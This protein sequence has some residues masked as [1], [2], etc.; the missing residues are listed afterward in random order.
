MARVRQL[1]LLKASALIF[2]I[3]LMVTS[4]SAK[5]SDY[6]IDAWTSDSGLP[7]SSVTS[8]A[9]TQDGY[10]WVGTS[11]GLARFDGVRFETFD[12][13]N[14]PELKSARITKLSVDAWGTLWINTG[15]GSMTS[16]RNGSF[17]SEWQGKQVFSV[18]SSSNQVL[19][20]LAGHNSTMVRRTGFGFQHSEWENIP[21]AGQVTGNSIQ[22]DGSGGIWYT[23]KKDLY[24]MVGTNSELMTPATGY[25]GKSVMSMSVDS[26]GHL[27]IG[28]D[29]GIARWNQGRFEDQTP[30]NGEPK[31]NV[32]SLYCTRNGCWVFADD[33]VR[34]FVDRQWVT[35]VDATAWKNL[36][37]AFSLDLNVYENREGDMWFTHLGSGLFHLKPDGRAEH[38]SIESGLPSDLASCCFQDREG[39]IWAGLTRGG[40]VRLRLK[41][42]QVIGSAEGMVAPAVSSVCQD[43]HSNVWIGTFSGGIY[44]WR[45]EKLDRFTLSEG[46]YKDCFYS[47]WPDSQNRLWLS[48]GRE[49]LFSL[50]NEQI[51][52]SAKPV[53]G[54]KTILVDRQD[55]VW[56]GR[57]NGL[58]CLAKGS[59]K[60]FPTTNG[61]INIRSL[62]EDPT[63]GIWIGTGDGNLFHFEDGKFTRYQTQN[64]KIGQAIWSLLPEGDGTLWMGIFRGGL[65]RFKDG[66]FTRYDMQDGLPNDIICQILDDGLGKLW[67][68]SHKGIFCIPKKSFQDLDEGKIQSLPC[69]AYGLND[70]LPT[71]ECSGSYQPACWHGHDGRLWFATAKGLVSV[72]PGDLSVNR[73][74]PPVMIEEVLVDGKP[75]TMSSASRTF[76]ISPGK[77]QLDFRYTALSFMAPDKMVFRYRLQ[78]LEEDWVDGGTKRS[79]H[80]GPLRPDKYRFQVIACNNDGVWNETGAAINL[81]VQPYF[82]QTWWFEFSTTVAAIVAL[83]LTVRYFVKA[84]M[85]RK[86]ERLE[87][88][89]AVERERQ[90]IARDIHDDLGAGLTQILLQS[91]LASRES[92]GQTQTDLNQ[93]SDNTRELVRKMDEIVWAVTPEK[94]TLDS[95]VTYV[96]KFV[97]EFC[98]ATKIRCRMDLPAQ[99]PDIAVSTETRHSVFL[100]IK[101]VMNNI[102]KHAGA[103]EASLQLKLLPNAFTFV[104]R[105]DG[106][107]LK[108]STSSAPDRLFSGRGLQNITQRLEKI[109][110]AFVLSSDSGR[111]TQ[112]ELTV[113]IN[114]KR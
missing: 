54:I 30:T 38:F 17:V 91:S 60:T 77:H 57:L 79:A 69:V 21:L 74:P 48:G 50:E 103:T 110:G 5:T 16:L 25:R 35:E 1:A 66:K 27:W 56:L 49:D 26:D 15:G 37:A 45:D 34:K 31:V 11:D 63:G 106:V 71:L 98:A 9:Q 29:E 114:P 96:G 59:L 40:L 22:Q 104:I 75:Q 85:R 47:A 51:I 111:G 97:Q 94:D 108:A 73:L 33:K 20:S 23:V 42:F 86:L 24:R 39:N 28:T 64:A 44:R 19:L 84:K 92:S 109:G 4:L 61:L 99:L 107:G 41:Q 18:F 90:R 93:I 87:Q 83:T 101:E 7:D 88:A 13:I 100:A 95:L 14:T 81:M 55:R 36:V 102:A 58:C 76:L 10:L 70:G 72:Q 89:H 32:S 6:L 113:Q 46:A 65:L 80:Y 12:P 78:G 112:V 67:I 43:A 52:P 53:H 62:A 2:S 8:I 82:W 3:V 68:G 105:D